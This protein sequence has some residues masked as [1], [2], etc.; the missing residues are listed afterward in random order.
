MVVDPTPILSHYIIN[1]TRIEGNRRKTHANRHF[2]G[3]GAVCIKAHTE[4]NEGANEE[5]CE[6]NY[7]IS[8]EI[9]VLECPPHDDDK[10]MESD[11]LYDG[12][13]HSIR[14]ALQM[15]RTQNAPK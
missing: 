5:P 2:I 1:M 6:T 3:V 12:R 10:C 13:K 4:P 9:L 14:F 8:S 7:G 15:K 11:S